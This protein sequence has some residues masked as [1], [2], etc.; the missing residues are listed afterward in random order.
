MGNEKDDK[1]PFSRIVWMTLAQQSHIDSV[2]CCIA[3]PER[4]DFSAWNIYQIAFISALLPIV[5]R[6]AAVGGIFIFPSI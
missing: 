1:R 5:A 4:Q 3:V 6:L 2:Q